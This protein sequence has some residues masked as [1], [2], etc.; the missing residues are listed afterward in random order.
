[1][2]ELG[3]IKHTNLLHWLD[4][5]CT[6]ETFPDI[7]EKTVEMV[8]KKSYIKVMLLML[9]VVPGLIN[10]T[11]LSCS[12]VAINIKYKHYLQFCHREIR[13]LSL[14]VKITMTS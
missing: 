12:H 8:H 13:S 4:V 2:H 9:F 5:G 10:H 11:V 7:F 14:Q 3:S 6:C 1:M